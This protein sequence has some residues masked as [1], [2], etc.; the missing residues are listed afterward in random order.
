MAKRINVDIGK[1]MKVTKKHFS[2]VGKEIMAHK[3]GILLGALFTTI[4]DNIK[5]H[6]EKDAVEKAYEK[7]SVKYQSI[8]RKNE[9]K[10]QVLK[11]KADRW[12]Q[13]DE[14]IQQLEQV[15]QEISEERSVN[16]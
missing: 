15:V 13:A 7:D 3:D 6:R 5:T 10:M 12:D 1:A 16:E 4:F 11:E 14:L 9:A 2:Q 8:A